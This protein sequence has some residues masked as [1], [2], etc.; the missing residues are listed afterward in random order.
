MRNRTLRA[1]ATAALLAPITL[2]AQQAT[3]GQAVPQT[4]TVQQ[5]ETL[6]TL[7]QKY[8][9]DSHL[10][11]EIYRL[12]K[13]A[14]ADPHWIY[15]GQVLK[16]PGAVTSVEVT[17]QPPA[18]AADTVRRA[19]VAQTVQTMDAPTV[20]KRDVAV[21]QSPDAAQ[22]VEQFP[23][24]LLGQ[25]ER[26][27]YVVR[28]GAM[29]GVGRVLRSADLDAN[30]DIEPTTIFKAYDDVLIQAPAGVSTAK[31]ARYVALAMGPNVYGV[32]QV[33]IP[34]GIVEVTRTP[35]AGTAGIGQVVQLFGEMNP[36]QVL[37]PLDTAGVSSTARPKP[38]KDGRWATIK[39][40]MAEPVLPT[41]QSY[42]V[43]DVTAGDGIR[44]GDEFEVFRTR[45]VSRRVG[46]LAEPEIPIG[47]AQVIK[48]TPFGTT[49][50]VTAQQQPAINTGMMVRNSAKMP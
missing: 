50:I 18:G 41:L 45:Q 42:V 49:A 15:P 30:G 40:V 9:Q 44:P 3:G 8:L 16:L 19:V 23:T 27:P 17:I 48:V 33:V 37:V 39:W 12:N 21:S 34:T 1:L 36:G 20:F 14:I 11:P 43:L 7:A 35:E 10:W 29:S 4:H 25:Y 46:G 28:P 2:A 24:V 38:L 22:A 31:G 6:W 26:A 13:D 32:G 47:K 5:G